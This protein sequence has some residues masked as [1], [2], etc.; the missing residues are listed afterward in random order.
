MKSYYSDK[1]SAEDLKRCYDIAPPRVQQYLAAE[2]VHVRSRIKPGDCILELGCGYGRILTALAGSAGRLVGIDISLSSLHMAQDYLRERDNVSIC[3]MDAVNMGF[4]A[5]CFDVVFCIQNGIS[6][7]HV[8]RRALINSAVSVTKPGGHVLSYA[9]E[10][11]H[12]R[13]GWFRMQAAHG[14]LGEI[15]E[16][17]T[18]NGMIICK[19]G[20]RATT[21]S[22]E[23]FIRL[24]EHLGK[25]VS[26]EQVDSSSVFCEITV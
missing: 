15:D 20:F 18:G 11:W 24:T 1:L 25:Q 3:L 23:E 26:I 8:D 9:E 12:E 17:K 19:D 14:L 21:V 2:I 16:D 10:F 22:H 7:F 6:A 13:L 4:R 5:A